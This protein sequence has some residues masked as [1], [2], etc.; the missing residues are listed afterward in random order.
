MSENENKPN[1]DNKINNE[2]N[3]KENTVIEMPAKKIAKQKVLLN[4]LKS[5]PNIKLS[6]EEDRLFYEKIRRWKI[7]I[8]DISLTLLD[9]TEIIN[10]F[11][12]III[13]CILL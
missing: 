8:K 9:K 5:I 2:N 6:S 7:H 12:Q 11:F 13:G 1:E 3:Q 4:T 10:G